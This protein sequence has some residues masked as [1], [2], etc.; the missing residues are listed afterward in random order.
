MTRTLGLERGDESP[1]GCQER[2]VPHTCGECICPARGGVLPP[3]GLVCAD[4]G[5]PPPCLTCM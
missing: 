5:R 2:A 1:P 4:A 3:G